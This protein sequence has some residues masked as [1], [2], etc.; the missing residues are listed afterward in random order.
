MKIAPPEAPATGYMFGKGLY[1]ADMYQKSAAYS[2]TNSDS[3]I[4]MLCDVACGKMKRL[5]QAT[6]VTNLERPFNSVHGVGLKGPDHTKSLVHPDGV[7]IPIAPVIEYKKD[8]F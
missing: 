5:Y 1:F 8:E 3:T 6:E 4:L 2:R 7:Q